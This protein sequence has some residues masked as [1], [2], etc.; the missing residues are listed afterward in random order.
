MFHLVYDTEYGTCCECLVCG[1]LVPDTN[2]TRRLHSCKEQERADQPEE[3]P[4]NDSA[5]IVEVYP[6]PSRTS[7]RG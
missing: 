4:D 5:I 6:Q 1:Q 2:E 7:E 3:N